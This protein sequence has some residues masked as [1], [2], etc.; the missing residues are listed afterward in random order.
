MSTPGRERIAAAVLLVLAP[1]LFW[2]CLEAGARLAGVDPLSEDESYM[3]YVR[4]R[5]CQFGWRAAA[6]ACA[7]DRFDHGER[8]L[9][10]ALGGSSVFGYPAWTPSF[11][12]KLDGLLK[13]AAP[14]RWRVVNRGYSCKNSYFVQDC[15]RRALEAGADVLVIY[16]GHNDFAAY[17]VWNPSRKIWLEKIAWVYD[18]ENWL[19]RSSAFSLLIGL[20]RSEAAPEWFPPQP[21]P[22]RMAAAQEIVLEAYTRNLTSIIEAAAGSDAQIILSTIVSNLYEFPVK[23]DEWD[24][25]PL[26]DP[27]ERPDLIPWAERYREG[28]V[29]HRAG[30]FDGA[31]SAFS[32]ARDRFMRGRAPAMLNERI[33]ELA[34]RHEHVELVDFE[35]RLHARAPMGIGCNF[36]GDE[37]Y[38][39]QF[40]PNDR[41]QEMI[42]RA[43]LLK[44]REMGLV[45]ERDRR[46]P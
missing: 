46:Q 23:R 14:R 13:R 15:A 27:D 8:K 17:G 35:R 38:C 31:L 2:G 11:A 45:P 22:E 1:A 37:S 42:A 4:E 5:G 20:L 34:S 21:D 43:L 19:A 10:V 24:S 29:M 41:T 7:L 30:D 39:D 44:M 36:F 6:S 3:A 16:A 33:R 26:F 25:S 40:H 12:P 32:A 9:L 18:L 28:I